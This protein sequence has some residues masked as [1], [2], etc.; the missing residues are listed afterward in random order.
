MLGNWPR[1]LRAPAGARNRRKATEK[2]EE[3]PLKVR[4]HEKDYNPI[5]K[6]KLLYILG[7]IKS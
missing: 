5:F 3:S 7:T 2:Y 1:R 4:C 6:K